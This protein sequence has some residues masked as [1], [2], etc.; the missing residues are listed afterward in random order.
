MLTEKQVKEIRE[1][2]EVS[3]NP[4]FFFDNDPDGLCSYL[5]L[6]RKYCKGKGVAVRSFPDL[7][8]SYFSKIKEFD[9]DYI[10]ILDKP[11][12]SQEFW[13]EIEKTNIPVVW[14]D[15]HE[16]QG[17]IPDFVN[18]Y[19]PLHERGKVAP[20]TYLS[21]QISRR[22]EDLWLGVVGCI[23]DKFF[24]DFY[25][26]F[27]KEYPELSI[28][29][30][31]PFEILYKSEIGK[32]A[33]V[34][35]F[36]LKDRT[37]NVVTMTKFL[38]EVKSPNEVLEENSKN[39]LMHKRFKYIEKRYQKFLEKA[40]NNSGDKKVLFFQ[41]GGDLSISSDLS[42]QLSFEFPKKII[43]VIYIAGMK[44][45]I[46][47]RGKKI[48]E[49][50]LKAIEGLEWATAGGHEDAVGAKVN[51]EDLDRFKLNLLGEIN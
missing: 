42:N 21:Y 17:E 7:N 50:V 34:L 28:K 9:S 35:G 16:I 14:I 19:N 41:Y 3:Q 6:K 15:H 33:M 18:Y 38:E 20:V 45:N 31:E 5:I 8:K 12:V 44:A 26:E 37:S 25:E 22:K 11:V 36:G 4:V 51:V 49:K 13:E 32:I 40:R 10:F 47:V 23:S 29:S 2:L 39:R 46:S 1:H 43:V 27:K 48:R 24:P 30:K